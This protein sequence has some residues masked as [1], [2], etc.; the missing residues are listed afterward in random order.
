MLYNTALMVSAIPS[1]YG[2]WLTNGIIIDKPYTTSEAIETVIID[3]Y[4]LSLNWNTV[5]IISGE[6]ISSFINETD[7]IKNSDN[8][9]IT[10]K[11]YEDTQLISLETF[12]ET[13]TKYEFLSGQIN[14]Q[15][16]YTDL[17][18]ILTI[19]TGNIESGNYNLTLVNNNLAPI[20]KTFLISGEQINLF[21]DETDFLN[22]NNYIANTTYKDTQI[23]WGKSET[24]PTSMI[25]YLKLSSYQVDQTHDYPYF[26]VPTSA[27]ITDYKN[28]DLKFTKYIPYNLNYIYDNK[29]YEYI[30]SGESSLQTITTIFKL[31]VN[32]DGTSGYVE[33]LPDGTNT[34]LTDY[35]KDLDNKYYSI[36]NT[37]NNEYT[38]LSISGRAYY[39][40]A[41]GD[42]TDEQVQAQMHELLSSMLITTS[43]EYNN[44]KLKLISSEILL[45][46]IQ[47]Y[48]SINGFNV[49]FNATEIL[50]YAPTG[51]VKTSAN[52]EYI[53]GGIPSSTADC[54]G[55]ISLTEKNTEYIIID[56]GI[57]L[58]LIWPKV[59]YL[60]NIVNKQYID[61]Y[62]TYIEPIFNK[63]TSSNYTLVSTDVDEWFNY[64]AKEYHDS[65][66]NNLSSNTTLPAHKLI[67]TFNDI[68]D[69][70]NSAASSSDSTSGYVYNLS[71]IYTRQSSFV[72]C[73]NFLVG[74]EIN[75]KDGL[76]ILNY[77][78]EANNYSMTYNY[79]MPLI[80][81]AESGLATN[82]SIHYYI[83]DK[84]ILSSNELNEYNSKVVE[85]THMNFINDLDRNY[86]YNSVGVTEQI[87]QR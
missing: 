82:R 65:A 29:T 12:P 36:L 27:D 70:V 63:Y 59:E 4:K 69:K 20:I 43:N 41:S 86:I 71:G 54:T 61:Q 56:N 8:N 87:P 60:D 25:K 22:N 45:S 55:Y 49:Y 74:D 33:C 47:E 11:I 79:H 35:N 15:Y 52:F 1:A 10:A 46:G 67:S 19:I 24:L 28:K 3:D 30:P 21:I 31:I 23:I 85:I 83:K 50:S 44:A 64:Y 68:S 42:Y 16:K 17:N 34:L 53:S 26:I 51:I 81:F 62:I 18:D 58:N 14:K 7:I 80:Q 40:E 39:G 5:Y 78:C 38:G 76:V 57:K 32:E 6:Q 9:A 2:E 13:L 73:T 84:K 48:E 75:Y 37:L 77:L 66:V 72:N